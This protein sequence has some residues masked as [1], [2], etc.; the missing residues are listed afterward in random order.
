MVCS[1]YGS[2]SIVLC[3][4]ALQDEQGDD[5]EGAQAEYTVFGRWINW[6]MSQ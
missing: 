4:H 2:I 5:E 6:K 3:L 1:K